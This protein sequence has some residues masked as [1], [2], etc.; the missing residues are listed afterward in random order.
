MFS[1]SRWKPGH[2]LLSW[3][4]YWGGLVAVKLGPTL[5]EVYRVTQL[6]E[7]HGSINAGFNNSVLNVSIVEDGVTT[8]A[9]SAP[10]ST[11]LVWVLVPPI[12]LWAIWLFVRVRQPTPSLSAHEQAALSEGTA[13]ATEWRSQ[14]DRV[15]ADR[16]H[17]PNP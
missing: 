16:I 9:S 11:I 13:P 6:P 10:L 15:P 2:L 8:L 12:V 7:G 5:R 1:I 4:A 3:G 14:N 17:T